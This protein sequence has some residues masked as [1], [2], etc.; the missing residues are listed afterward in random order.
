MS[1]SQDR[2]AP[3]GNVV[4]LRPAD[5]PETVPDQPET[6]A[7]VSTSPAPG[8]LVHR[9]QYII[10][11]P[12]VEYDMVLTEDD[13]GGGDGMEPRIA[14]LEA[15]VD[16]IKTDISEIKTDIKELRKDQR[17]DFRELRK[18]QRADFRTLF[19][20]LITVAIGLA[21][22]MAKGFKWF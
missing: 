9:R 1:A 20:A 22:I 6:M 15:D 5:T 21:G 7:S 2:S 4:P 18:D 8:Y 10:D 11:D 3:R 16:H 17:A 13:G 19:A 12:W 14:K